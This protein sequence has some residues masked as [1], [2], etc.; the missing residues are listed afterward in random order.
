ML[1]STIQL[2]NKAKYTFYQDDVL[3]IS[4]SHVENPKEKE[5]VFVSVIAL[6]AYDTTSFSLIRKVVN[7][8]VG[9]SSWRM[10]KIEDEEILTHNLLVIKESI[11]CSGNI[12]KFMYESISQN[13][14]TKRTKVLSTIS[15][16][17]QFTILKK[18]SLKNA[19]INKRT[20]E[21]GFQEVP[22]DMEFIQAI[23]ELDRVPSRTIPLLPSSN[24]PVN[25]PLGT[26]FISPQKTV[27]LAVMPKLVIH[28]GSD[29]KLLTGSIQHLI[30]SLIRA[31]KKIII[32]DFGN[33]LGGLQEGLNQEN[34]FPSFSTLL[35]GQNYRVNLCDIEIPD[36]LKDE[37]SRRLFQ[38]T[39]ISYMLALAEENEFLISHLHHLKHKLVEAIIQIS[40]EKYSLVDISQSE[41]FHDPTSELDHTITNH[42]ADELKFYSIIPELNYASHSTEDDNQI[43]TTTGI[44]LF[45][46]PT[47]S[48]V[49]KRAIFAFLFQKIALRCDRNTAVI[50]TNASEIFQ[51]EPR[52]SPRGIYEAALGQYYTRIVQSS[53]LILS[54]YSTSL[55]SSIQKDIDTGIY[56]K[57][58][59]AKDREWLSLKY[60]LE[61]NIE[62]PDEFLKNTDGEGLLFREDAPHSFDYF[63]PYVL[64]PIRGMAR[65][66]NSHTSSS[67]QKN[68]SKEH[69]AML[70]NLLQLIREIPY[71]TREIVHVL[72]NQGFKKVESNINQLRSFKYFLISENG[73]KKF[74]TISKEGITYFD[75]FKNQIDQLPLPMDSRLV[76]F[77]VILTNLRERAN[78]IEFNDL[79]KCQQL[80]TDI[81]QF[82]GSLTSSYFQSQGKIDWRVFTLFLSLNEINEYDNERY[83]KGIDLLEHLFSKLACIESPLG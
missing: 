41:V 72:K 2:I 57:F 45:Q 14:L 32:L 82:A 48:Y 70:L 77:K 64:G 6:I 81:L 74:L 56:Y 80:T 36:D 52:N 35:L 19:F 37:Q 59:N 4:I 23:A 51:E 5:I 54:T 21:E 10:N 71:E 46:F 42:L 7:N 78:E 58:L 29:R 20:I 68:L 47:Q 66:E 49:V 62:N 75:K 22:Y 34:M 18:N 53:C 13:L 79:E 69:I 28:A 12:P 3:F 9:V 30:K 39:T 33:E 44:R 61:R 83:L 40:N 11:Y 1:T 8:N 50:V 25:I 16:S 24:N 27:G 73:E 76:S 43:W 67:P 17:F 63:I 31:E 38:S 55:H 65:L 15:N 60:T 26:S